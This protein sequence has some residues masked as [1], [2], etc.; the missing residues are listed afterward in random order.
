MFR[1]LVKEAIVSKTFKVIILAGLLVTACQPQ[2]T[3]QA[4]VFPPGAHDPMEI[5]LPLGIGAA[6]PIPENN[7]MTAA[8]VELGKQLFF[9]PRLSSDGTV[10][11]ATCHNPVL[12]FT[13]GRPVSMGVAGQEGGRSAPTVINLAYAQLGVFWDGR[14]KDLEEQAVG[15]IANP[16]EMANTHRGAVATLNGIP[17]YQAQFEAIFGSPDI[18]IDNVGR[19]IAAFERTIISGNSAWDR[20]MSGDQNALSES[21]QRGWTLFEDREK[22]NCTACHAGFNLTDNQ[23]HN[24]GVGMDEENPD[25][26]RYVVT[27]NEEDRGRFKTPTLRD[28]LYTRPYM[29]DG[30]FWTLEEV[31][32]FYDEGGFENPTLDQEIKP[33][34]LT[35]QE[36]ADLVEFMKALDGEGWQVQPPTTLPQPAAGS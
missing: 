17:G 26:G 15:P 5:D 2:T 23:Y 6:P 19:A 3:D 33:L 29:H 36:K 7:P 28:I 25:A 34:R 10:S 32:D 35:D 21:A 16:I 4:F 30:R 31:V 20:F 9:D 13:D 8:K 11:C 22:S 27:Q 1:T 12:G 24:L 14:A 18:T